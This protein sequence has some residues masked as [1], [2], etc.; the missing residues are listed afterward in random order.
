MKELVFDWTELA[1]GHGFLE[2]PV[3][4]G[5]SVVFTSINR[6]ML[7][8][9]PLQGGTVTP[10]AETGGGPNGVA[11]NRDGVLWVAQNGGHVVPSRSK[12]EA[13]PSIQRVTP[14]GRVSVAMGTGLLAPNDCAFGPDGRLWF[15]DPHGSTIGADRRPGALWALDTKSGEAEKILDGL[16]HP[17]G[18]VFGPGGDE[19]FVGETHRGRIIRLRRN[20]RGWEHAGAYATLE[21]GEPDGMAFDMDGRLWVAASAGDA[22]VVF[23]PGAR[24]ASVVRLGPSFPTN[25]CFAGADRRT[26][27]VTLPKGGR[28]ISTR[29]DTAGLPLLR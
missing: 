15:T 17:N 1:A 6:G 20:A 5:D 2:G 9:V 24:D 4:C 22:I 25:L 8:R 7:Y 12:L 11:I 13:V 10:V 23:G 14:D 28:V 16:A 27:V 19:L 18:L 29:V 3:D 26:L 21:V